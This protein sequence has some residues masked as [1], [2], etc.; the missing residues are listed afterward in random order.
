MLPKPKRFGE[1]LTKAL[2]GDNVQVFNLAVDGYGTNQSLLA[3][4]EYGAKL[5]PAISIYNFYI[6]DIR[7]NLSMQSSLTISENGIRSHFTTQSWLRTIVT[8]AREVSAFANYL[9]SLAVNWRY[10]KEGTSRATR[11]PL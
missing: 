5:N 7:D 8:R 10:K 3:W 1:Q 11:G 2:G 6:N 4:S 9:Y